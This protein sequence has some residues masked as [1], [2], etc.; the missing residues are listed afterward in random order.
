[1]ICLIPCHLLPGVEN[2]AEVRPLLSGSESQTDK[3]SCRKA[4][5][6][7]LIMCVF[8]PL[9]LALLVVALV[10]A[11]P[12][13]LVGAYA[14]ERKVK[15]VLMSFPWIMMLLLV[16][17]LLYNLGLWDRGQ[18]RP[19][20]QLADNIWSM[21]YYSDSKL[22]K[23]LGLISQIESNCIIWREIGGNKLVLISPAPPT[24][25]VVQMISALGQVVL[26][27]SPGNGHDQHAHKWPA[28][29][30]SCQAACFRELGHEPEL[31][32]WGRRVDVYSEDVLGALGIRW[33]VVPP[34]V[35]EGA[36]G[37]PSATKARVP[38]KE[39][40]IQLPIQEVAGRPI[41]YALIFQD[42]IQNHRY[43]KTPEKAAP[44]Y[45]CSQAVVLAIWG[46]Y[47]LRVTRFYRSMFIAKPELLKEF[48]VQKI[49]SLRDVSMLLPLHG[50]PV[51]GPNVLDTLKKVVLRL[52]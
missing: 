1:M 47:G 23:K 20:Q 22:G 11:I 33:H 43:M 36:I 35:F 9:S 46:L 24:D 19:P 3:R 27:V 49:C 16:R 8:V 2:D 12:L 51:T 28:R 39:A 18:T 7:T 13:R 40:I 21:K 31:K 32:E 52:R 37:L 4:C 44:L 5:I 42:S 48:F 14:K 6:L 38:I 17:T 15:F 41:T 50:P 25:A 45:S 10:L 26:A 29:V 30:E 34:Q